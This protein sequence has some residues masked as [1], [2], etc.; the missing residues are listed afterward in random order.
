MSVLLV[1]LLVSIG[2]VRLLVVY[3]ILSG[4]ERRKRIE[5]VFVPAMVSVAGLV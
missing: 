3:E 2:A 1:G 5:V 4:C